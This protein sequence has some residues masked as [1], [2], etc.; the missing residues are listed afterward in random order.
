MSRKLSDWYFSAA[1]GLMLTKHNRALYF[2][3]QDLVA[4]VARGDDWEAVRTEEPEAQFKAMLLRHEDLS[5]ALKL[6]KYVHEVQPRDWP[7]EDFEQMAIDWR[8]DVGKL[9]GGWAEI[10]NNDRF[11]VLQQVSSVL[12]IGLTNDVES[13]LR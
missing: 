9:A 7:S 5:A 12:R 10:D 6:M 8:K 1:G 11:A 3:F 2:A 4:A 13:R